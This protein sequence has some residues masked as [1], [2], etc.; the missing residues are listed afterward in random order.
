MPEQVP[1]KVLRRSLAQVR[2]GICIAD[3]C[4][5]DMPLVYVNDAFLAMTGY[6]RDELIGFNCRVLH[7]NANANAN[8]NQQRSLKTIHSALA[9][10]QP[11]RVA[12]RN[13]RKDG[14]RFWN[15][16][17]LTPIFN[18]RGELTH[19]IGVQQDITAERETKS[20]L[21]KYQRQLRAIANQLIHTQEAERQRMAR[22]IHD[23]VGQTLSLC[24]MQLGQLVHDLGGATAHP[25]LASVCKLVES[26]IQET[27][28]LMHKLSPP[29]LDE[30]GLPAALRWLGEQLAQRYGM[31]V[32]IDAAL[33]RS[34]AIP[35]NLA[36]M[37]YR[38]ARE[39]MINAYKHADAQSV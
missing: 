25:T 39:L 31:A 19:Y 11:C 7:T 13:Y 34:P 6:G 28:G 18:E 9:A 33:P 2:H 37:V 10:R 5:P 26:S 16:L 4:Q 35:D 8:A 27:R 32:E 15:D 14:T 20:R 38:S 36:R 24:R 30:L 12:L 17:S 29:L 1:V 3:A 21:Q 22:E 23:Q